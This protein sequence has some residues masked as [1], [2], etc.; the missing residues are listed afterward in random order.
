M[1]G[2]CFAQNMFHFFSHLLFRPGPL[3][4]ASDPPPGL[5]ALAARLHAAS[6]PVCQRPT[7]WTADRLPLRAPAALRYE[8]CVRRIFFLFVQNLL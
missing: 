1:V 5:P 4:A 6:I 2:K 3:L 8:S 7:V